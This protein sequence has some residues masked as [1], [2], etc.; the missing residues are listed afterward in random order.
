MDST[1]VDVR[2]AA[3]V[4]CVSVRMVQKLV[5][6]GELRSLCVGRC[7]RFRPEDLRDF[8]E[9]RRAATGHRAAVA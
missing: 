8:I 3:E 1:L 4:L 5:E 2:R 9:S 6:R 7:R